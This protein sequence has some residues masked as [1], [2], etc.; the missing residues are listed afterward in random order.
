MGK[1]GK[2]QNAGPYCANGYRHNSNA[3]HLNFVEGEDVFYIGRNKFKQERNL[4]NGQKGVVMSKTRQDRSKTN[5]SLIK[6]DFSESG[7]RFVSKQLLQSPSDYTFCLED[8]L[9][10]CQSGTQTTRNDRKKTI[11][12]QLRQTKYEQTLAN[13]EERKRFREWRKEYLDLLE[14]RLESDYETKKNSQEIKDNRVREA[15]I[16]KQ[17]RQI[18]EKDDLTDEDK[19]QIESYQSEIKQISQL[20]KDHYTELN[21]LKEMIQ[22]KASRK[23]VRCVYSRPSYNDYL[24]SVRLND[25][26]PK[27][28]KPSREYTV[29]E[30]TEVSDNSIQRFQWGLS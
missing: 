24:H 10:R 20:E 22:N 30:S 14:S 19:S 17:I 1:Y 25:T 5:R 3:S 15:E 26:Y 21:V 2:S 4:T 29:N 28:T 6:V 23:F 12:S 18:K 8:Q 11:Q 16:K 7:V 13:R 27:I 9:S